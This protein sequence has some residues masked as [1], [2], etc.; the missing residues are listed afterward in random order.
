[1]GEIAK[2]WLSQKSDSPHHN[3]QRVLPSS[4][5]ENANNMTLTRE[6]MSKACLHLF[7]TPLNQAASREVSS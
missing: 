3:C 2:H 5:E 1:M 6:R 7:N 4:R